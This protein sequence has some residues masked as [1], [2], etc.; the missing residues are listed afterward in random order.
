MSWSTFTAP[1]AGLVVAL[2]SAVHTTTPELNEHLLVMHMTTESRLP[3]CHTRTGHA[4]L[5]LVFVSA[6]IV[7]PRWST[8]ESAGA[9]Q[10]YLVVV[11]SRLHVAVVYGQTMMFTCPSVFAQTEVRMRLAPHSLTDPFSVA[12]VVCLSRPCGVPPLDVVV[13]GPHVA[14]V[15]GQTAV[16]H[17]HALS[18]GSVFK[19]TLGVA[20][21]PCSVPPLVQM[22]QCFTARL[23]G[24]L[25]FL[26]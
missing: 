25:V 5:A 3:N 7:M 10:T 19:A 4:A 22:S 18:D 17:A 1:K 26:A 13:S 15:Y 6:P 20:Q 23:R 2:A 14:A 21:K 9:V 16:S 12:H 24:T 11:A 8:S